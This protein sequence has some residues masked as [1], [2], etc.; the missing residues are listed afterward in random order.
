MKLQHYMPDLVLLAITNIKKFCTNDRITFLKATTSDHV[1]QVTTT[2]HFGMAGLDI[3][4]LA[5]PIMV[6]AGL[7]LCSSSAYKTFHYHK[8]IYSLL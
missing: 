8:I 3:M 1:F 5:I 7:G 6:E 2:I 4:S